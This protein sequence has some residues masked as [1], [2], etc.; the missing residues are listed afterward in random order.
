M[1]LPVKYSELDIARRRLIRQ[2]YIRLQDNTCWFC[3]A[4]LDKDPP[5]E[6]ADKPIDHSLFPETFFKY[7]IHLHHDHKTDMTIGA[8]HSHCNA[9][10]W[11][12]Y[13]E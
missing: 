6:I 7:P 11:Q 12:Y 10:L 2:E 9:V 13:G 1:I 8:V 5:K 4:K 3:F